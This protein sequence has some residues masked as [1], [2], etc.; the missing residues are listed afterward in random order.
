M[1]LH[2]WFAAVPPAPSEKPTSEA[3]RRA[4][5]TTA[6]NILIVE[7]EFFIALDAQEQAEQLGH[8]V[9]GIAVSAE[10]ALALIQG[11]KPD[12]VLM[13]I[14]LTGD[15]DGIDAAREIRERFGIQSIF[16]S[17][18][19]DPSTR[20]RAEALGP[21]A[22]LEKPLTRDRLGQVLSRLPNSTP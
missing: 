19:T 18:N 16:V 10:Q 4:L 5:G 13:D 8:R 12:V 3:D 14:R 1:S 7:D 9:I 15:R 6:L 21:L 22:F 20:R 11:E 17:A 2:P